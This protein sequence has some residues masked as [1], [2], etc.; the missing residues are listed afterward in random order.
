MITGEAPFEAPSATA[1]L[2]A[3]AAD[4]PKSLLEARPEVPPGLSVQVMKALE[5]APE[6]RQQTV[7]QFAAA[8][9]RYRDESTA[10]STLMSLTSI[11]PPAPTS[12]W[13]AP[14]VGGVALCVVAGLARRSASSAGSRR[15]RSPGRSHVAE[16]AEHVAVS[17]ETP[18]CVARVRTRRRRRTAEPSASLRRSTRSRRRAIGGGHRGS[19]A[20]LGI[21]IGGRGARSGAAC[22]S[23]ARHLASP[24]RP[25]PP[26][27]EAKPASK[28]DPSH[29]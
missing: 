15:G 1:V 26:Q 22:R 27:V 11:P 6:K 17:A 21:G 28:D 14:V 23:R 16:P 12:R 24:P 20:P 29:L 10:P 8:V 5:K 13:K 9:E 7:R 4:H 19:D 18:A 25:R 2:A 3:I